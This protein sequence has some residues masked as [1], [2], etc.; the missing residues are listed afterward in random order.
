MIQTSEWSQSLHDNLPVFQPILSGDSQ[1][2]DEKIHR[3]EK[4]VLWKIIELKIK[5]K[6]TLVQ[7]KV[8]E[9]NT[10]NV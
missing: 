10:E 8:T 6:T 2:A 5:L 1:L 3:G 4:Y 7:K 9:I